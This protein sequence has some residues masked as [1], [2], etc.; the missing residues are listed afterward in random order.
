[1]ISKRKAFMNIARWCEEAMDGHS[2]KAIAEELGVRWNTARDWKTGDAAPGSMNL[3][4]LASY[5]RYPLSE[6]DS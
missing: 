4:R 1:M 5:C 3:V 2:T 6:L